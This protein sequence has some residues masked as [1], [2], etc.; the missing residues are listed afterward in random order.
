MR[1]DYKKKKTE[2]VILSRCDFLLN[3]VLFTVMYLYLYY[4][5]IYTA[6][7]S[8]LGS[9]TVLIWKILV[10]TSIACPDQ[11][12]QADNYFNT[13]AHVFLTTNNDVI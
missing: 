2:V 6:V 3:I 8:A 13:T 12:V 11:A 4:N 7:E 5:L 9:D 10:N 1:L